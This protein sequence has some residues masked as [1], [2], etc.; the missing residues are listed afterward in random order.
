MNEIINE[1]KQFT[2]RTPNISDSIDPSYKLYL[3]ICSR[4]FELDDELFQLSRDEKDEYYFAHLE[5][6]RNEVKRITK[7]I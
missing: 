1:I 3:A 7:K 6:I 5:K 2:Q 4:L